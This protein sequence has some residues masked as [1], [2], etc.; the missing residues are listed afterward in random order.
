[1]A[2]LNEQPDTARI[3]I[4]VVTAMPITDQNRARLTGNV[5]AI[6]EKAGFDAGR[7]TTEVR[8]ALSGR[9]LVA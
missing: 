8:R 9:R 2:A 1:V 6:M 7:F 5:T 3:P 4:V